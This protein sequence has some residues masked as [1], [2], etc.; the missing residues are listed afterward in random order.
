MSHKT[1]SRVSGP[2]VPRLRTAGRSRL[3]RADTEASL[4]S[5]GFTSFILRQMYN[6]FSFPSDAATL[7]N[8][9]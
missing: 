6:K 9:W 2:S 5:R 4:W 8:A 3:Y 1:S 7:D